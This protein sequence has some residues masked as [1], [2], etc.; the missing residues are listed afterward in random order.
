LRRSRQSHNV[1]D[2]FDFAAFDLA[3]FFLVVSVWQQ[4]TNGSEA[5]AAVRSLDDF[6]AVESV[7]CSP[8][9]PDASYGGGGVDQDAIEIEEERAA[10]DLRH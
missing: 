7:L 6:I 3:I 4:F 1:G 9:V 5:G 2:I 8:S 10:G